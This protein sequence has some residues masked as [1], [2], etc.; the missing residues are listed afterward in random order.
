MFEY[1]KDSITIAA[2]LDTRR[3]AASGESPVKIRVTYRRD[4]KYYS[5][6]KRMTVA[7]WENLP[8]SKARSMIQVR[9]SIHN[10]FDIVRNAVEELASGGAFTDRKS[11]RLNSS[12]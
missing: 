8:S 1:S 11:T 5:T 10:S 4:R 3:A 7:E 6:G 9:E 2:I 12:H